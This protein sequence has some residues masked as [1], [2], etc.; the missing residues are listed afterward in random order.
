MHKP[1]W[2]RTT[3]AS[4]GWPNLGFRRSMLAP[5]RLGLLCASSFGVVHVVWVISSVCVSKFREIFPV[6]VL[7]PGALLKNNKNVEMI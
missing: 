6:L 7:V 5:V 2:W 3:G 4:A 1:S